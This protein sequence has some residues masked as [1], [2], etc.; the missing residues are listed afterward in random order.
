MAMTMNPNIVQAAQ[1]ITHSNFKIHK[2][3]KSK[4]STVIPVDL[5]V[6][7]NTILKNVSPRANIGVIVQAI[8]SGK[9]LY[10]RNAD[11][12]FTPASVNKLFV[13]IAA[14]DYLKP[15]YRFE[16]HVRFTGTVS[17]GILNGDLYVQFNGDP[18][19]T[20]RQLLNLLDQ[21]K[22]VGIN[23]INGHVY[24][25]NTAYG[26]AAYAPGWL[27]HDLIFG[28]A[29]PLNA[30]ILNENRF[31]IILSPA[32]KNG[33]PAS[34]S[35]TIPNGIVK[36][37][38]NTITRIQR[39]DC[40]LSVLSD[41]D[42][43]YHVSGC[44]ANQPAK[45]YFGL[46]LRDPVKYAKV[47][48]ANS[49]Q[50]NQINFNGSIE[51]LGTP[52][53]ST[54]IATHQSPP[55][56]LIIKNM[57][58]SS[59]NLYT[60]SILKQIGHV[61]YHS[62]GTWQNG[63]NAIQ[64]ILETPANID[65]NQIHLFDGAGL[66]RYNQVSPRQLANL[67]HYAYQKPSVETD[68]WT[69]LPIAGQDGTLRGRLLAFAKGEPIHAKTGTM[70]GV[71]ALAGYINTRYNG[72][73]IFV[74]MTNSLHSAEDAHHVFKYTEDNICQFLLSARKSL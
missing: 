25:D 73:L 71:S 62:Q 36:I 10:Q 13:A 57:M 11:G 67:L 21:V 52:E 38:N 6:G 68:L 3:Y 40:P 23:Q 58:K 7:M 14:L 69:S 39:R 44:I 15:E 64:K 1:K 48:I 30:V 16:T 65:F 47:L 26:S 29:A 61:F 27:V 34:S 53:N 66:S 70:K 51:I 60:N 43:T 32:K 24:L 22:T 45:Q 35:T 46:A 2:T 50:K 20:E 37:N 41:S 59:D 63:L 72:L 31:A 33:L 74:I 28:F 4:L 5:A 54:V 8:G 42:N 56:N 19:L 9:I 49:L 17:Q 12:L 55:L 18:T